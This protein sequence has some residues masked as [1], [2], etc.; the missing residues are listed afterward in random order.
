MSKL[1]L[2]GQRMCANVL[3]FYKKARMCQNGD[4]K[5]TKS[6]PVIIP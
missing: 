3:C 4:F 2:D 6:L 1:V 5:Y